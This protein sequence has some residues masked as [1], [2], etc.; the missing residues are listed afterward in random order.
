MKIPKFAERKEIYLVGIFSEGKG[1][2]H[3]KKINNDKKKTVDPP[4]KS[5]KII[6]EIEKIKLEIP[7][8][9]NNQTYLPFYNRSFLS[10]STYSY[11]YSQYYRNYNTQYRNYPRNK[12]KIEDKTKEKQEENKEEKVETKE[13]KVINLDTATKKEFPILKSSN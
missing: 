5:L 11:P 9:N 12:F 10:N 6:S 7:N 13:K 3:I 8:Q 4:S 2:Q 1:Y